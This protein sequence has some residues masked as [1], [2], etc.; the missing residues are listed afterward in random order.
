MSLSLPPPRG[1]DDLGLAYFTTALRG[2]VF[3]YLFANILL[4]ESQRTLTKIYPQKAK[5]GH[6]GTNDDQKEEATG[7]SLK[8]DG[9]IRTSDS[10]TRTTLGIPMPMWSNRHNKTTTRS[11]LP[12]GHT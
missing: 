2:A 1:G 12:T 11:Q 5:G 6:N 4:L 3:C 9:D 10:A 7:P 8:R